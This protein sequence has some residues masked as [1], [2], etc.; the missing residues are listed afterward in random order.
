ME[1]KHS[2]PKERYILK[3]RQQTIRSFFLSLVDAADVRLDPDI[4]MH[5]FHFMQRDDDDLLRNY[6]ENYI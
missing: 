3:I 4:T 6:V 1:P 2:N 5:D